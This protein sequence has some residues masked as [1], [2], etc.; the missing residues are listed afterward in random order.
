MTKAK[1]PAR[2]RATASAKRAGATSGTAGNGLK[3]FSM[4]SGDAGAASLVASLRAERPA[5]AAFSAATEA[6]PSVDPETAA[7]RYLHQ[8]LDSP[9]VRSFS[10]PQA[11]GEESEFKSLGTVTVPLTGTK[12]VKYRQSYQGIP[13][14]GSLVTV[15]LDDRNEL[16]SL[17]SSLGQPEGVSPVAKISPDDALKAITKAPGY[18][19]DLTGIVPHLHFYFERPKAKW[20][21]VFI[22]EDV[23]VK[24]RGA[25]GGQGAQAARL[26]PLYMDYVV[27]AHTG[28]VVAELPRTPSVGAI[29]DSA[30]D[31]KGVI[32]QFQV[33]NGG[34]ANILL[35]TKA[36]IQTF[37]FRFGDPQVNESALPGRPIKNPPAWPPAAVSAHANAAAVAAFLRSVLL[38]NNI[39][40][41]GGPMNSSINCVVAQ[42]SS[43]GQVWLNAFW[44]GT[45]MVYGQTRDANGKL[46]SLSVD[47]DVVGHEMFHG[48]T[49]STS[50]LEYANQPGALN[51]SYS[52]I[53]GIII[54]NFDNPNV[55][56]WNWNVGEGMSTGGRPFR[57]MK[58]PTLFGQPAVMKNFQ[59][60]PNTERGDWG[61]VHINSGIHNKAAFLMLT[62][63]DAAGAFVLTPQQV[64]AFFY[65]ALTQQL[66]RT[67]Q[68]SDSRRGVLLSARTLFRNLPSA[69][70]TAKIDA[71]TKAFDAVG[72]K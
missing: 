51:E 33:E 63:K 49:D 10:A 34:A 64:A 26:A 29:I 25:S 27:D 30:K 43:D 37:D 1:K 3:T 40:D 21:L 12:V 6:L 60:L 41:K 13:V 24:R 14:Y 68:F 23:P 22:A 46:M 53:F 54:A 16:V 7:T 44:N 57:N 70:Q 2:A 31:G 5:T 69:E 48:V 20:R 59:T 8:A 11:N 52:D 62:A 4:H 9:S 18:T 39:D 45:Q 42:E 58:D 36:R 56:S 61:G 32:R 55:D 67:S 66:S 50:R 72:I 15:E 19:K 28:A 65:L 35:D 17:N 38:R 71:I 47:L